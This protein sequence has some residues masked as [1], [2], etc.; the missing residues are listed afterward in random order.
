MVVPT[1][2]EEGIG[3][4]DKREVDGRLVAFCRCGGSSFRVVYGEW[5]C[6]GVCV[7]CG[8]ESELYGG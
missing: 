5:Y 2:D 7:A 6:G 8:L 1:V 3:F 4:V